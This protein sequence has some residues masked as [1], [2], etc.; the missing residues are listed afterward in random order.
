MEYSYSPLSCF[1]S[2]LSTTV[3][4]I[5]DLLNYDLESFDIQLIMAYNGGNSSGESGNVWSGGSSGGKSKERESV[6]RKTSVVIV[7]CRFS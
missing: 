2:L 5:I 6:E 1:V 3:Q 4:F 7:A